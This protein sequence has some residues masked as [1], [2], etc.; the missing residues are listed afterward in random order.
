VEKKGIEFAIRAIAAVARTGRRLR[1]DVIG[2]GPLRSRLQRI[3]AELGIT[4]IVIIH[5]SKKKSEVI[6]MLDCAHV[7]LA[8]SVTAEDGD[9]EGIPVAIMEAMA[10]GLPVIST[11]HSGIP[12]L[13]R[14][15]VSGYLVEERDVES[16]AS[17]IADIVDHPEAW[18]E[19]GW[20]GRGIIEHDFNIDLLNDNLAAD[21]ATMVSAQNR[22]H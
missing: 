4:D 13:V 9:R 19:L 7:L 1:Y 21:L 18:V 17:K 15:G 20:A 10:A 16:L 6:A 14:D 8:P 3:V 12:E 11:R 5:G 22:S 2:D